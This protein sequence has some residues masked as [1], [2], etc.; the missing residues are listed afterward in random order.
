[1]IIHHNGSPFAE[2][3]LGHAG[4]DLI[5]AKGGDDTI[6][7]GEGRDTIHGGNDDD[8]IYNDLGND[9]FYGEGGRDTMSFAYIKT[10]NG[11]DEAEVYY[12]GVKFDLAKSTQKV[13]I[14][15]TDFYS[16]FEN[17]VGSAGADTLFGNDSANRL[18]G[19]GGSDWLNGRGG[20]D[21]IIGGNGADTING[22]R[23]GDKLGGTVLAPG[24]DDGQQD[25]FRYKSVKD[26]RATLEGRDTI[27]GTFDGAGNNGDRIDL[28][29]ID[30]DGAFKA[31]NGKFQ[32]IGDMDFAAD[33]IGE[34]QV[35]QL[36]SGDLYLVSIDTDL[37]AA[38]E[39]A[40]LVYSDTA[41]L[42]SDF[43]L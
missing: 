22:G 26:S 19:L 1:M 9:K 3:I 24:T 28:H 4:K 31:G 11:L 37:D 43:I 32:F 6:Y 18:N 33:R 27:W 34:V 15:G 8:L 16:G 13:G 39:M 36:G 25:I 17:A 29:L 40:I 12:G 10:G 2:V 5:H 23:G 42:S 35:R 20:R 30:A 41:L 14:F 21:S 7:S 38:P